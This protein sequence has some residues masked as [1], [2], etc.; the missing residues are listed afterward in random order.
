MTKQEI[1]STIQEYWKS[2]YKTGEL[3]DLDY[4]INRVQ[5]S[6]KIGNY[7]LVNSL[8]EFDEW[9]QEGKKRNDEY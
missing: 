1:N 8:M 9:V 2:L 5:E 7:F 6:R 4:C 3:P